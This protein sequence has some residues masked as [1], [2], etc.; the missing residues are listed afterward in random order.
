[1]H[2]ILSAKRSYEGTIIDW[3]TY[4]HTASAV[5]LGHETKL[6]VG[7]EERRTETEARRITSDADEGWLALPTSERPCRYS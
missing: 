5:A 4:R 7:E 1:M 6:L 3:Y 2:R